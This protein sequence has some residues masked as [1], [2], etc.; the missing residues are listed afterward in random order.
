MKRPTNELVSRRAALRVFGSVG[1]G[2]LL[3]CASRDV[4]ETDADGASS[5]SS[6]SGGA[7][8]SS[9]GSSSSSSGGASSSTSSGSA[10]SWA[11]GG[12]AVMTGDYPDPFPLAAAC[13]VLRSTTAGPCTE[14]ADHDRRDISE[15]YGGLPMRLA[16]RVVDASCNPIV[17]VQVKVWHTQRTGSYSGDTPNPNM[18]LS[19]SAEASKHYFRGVQTTDADG[20]VDFDTCF[21]G[22]Y[23]GRAIHIHFSVQT[24]SGELISQLGFEQSL[25]QEL[26]ESHPDY[27]EFG[28]PDTP[29]A[30]DNIFRD[31]TLADHML[32]TSRLAD[33]AMMAAKEVRV[34]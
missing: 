20:R 30:T 14:D 32:V 28:Q 29:N 26:F 24:G 19:S 17:G 18:C 31:T 2:L 1:A 23:R 7:G 25:I 11:T 4:D 3:A 15:G 22:W 8:S 12:T 34:G 27:A 33:G 16:L 21:P 13:L 9:G 5:S 10:A 6:G